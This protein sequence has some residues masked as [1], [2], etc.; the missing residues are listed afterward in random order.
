MRVDGN[1][2]S[3]VNYEPN[4]YDGPMED[5]A[6][7]EPPLKI[8]GDA[9][10]YNSYACDEDDYYGQP[11]MFYQNTLDDEGRTHLI[12]N[13]ATSL[14][15]VPKNIQC[16][17]VYHFYKVDKSFGEKVAKEIDVKFEDALKAWDS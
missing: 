13:L 12:Q 1:H 14:D 2:G 7:D 6:Y 17:Q 5:P 3:E 16:R 10:R 8:N 4:T 11:R 9:A 15:G